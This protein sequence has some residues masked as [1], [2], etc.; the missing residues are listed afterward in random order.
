[1]SQIIIAPSLL[2]CN[3]LAINDELDAFDNIP[4][5]WMHLDIMDG[6][7]V[8]NLTFGHPLVQKISQ[9][10]LHKL[11]AHLMVTNPEF[12]INSFKNYRIH[13]LTFHLETIKDPLDFIKMAKKFYPSVGISIKPLTP[14]SHLSDQVLKEVDLILV[15]S[16]EPGFAGQ[17]FLE[18]T[19]QKLNELVSVKKSL[20][21]HF[22][23]QVDGGVNDQNAF[24]LIQHGVSV[25]VAGSYLFKNP[26]DK[27]AGQIEKLRG[28]VP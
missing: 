26:S 16:V 10:T 6:H 13:N 18:N 8:P 17:A 21:A 24:K 4:N 12:Y 14:V 28:N 5:L 23:I 20:N 7:F 27:Y 2:A 15:M 3:F 25:L 11:D 22:I 9:S 19:Y 1:M